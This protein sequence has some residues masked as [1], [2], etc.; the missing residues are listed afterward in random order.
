MRREDQQYDRKNPSMQRKR[1]KAFKAVRQSEK[2]VMT[3][4]HTF[5]FLKNEVKEKKKHL[6]SSVLKF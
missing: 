6:T 5:Y 2:I 3:Y 4:L 1:I